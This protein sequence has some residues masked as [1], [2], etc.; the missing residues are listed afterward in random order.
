MAYTGIG[1]VVRWGWVRN[2]QL[3]D[4]GVDKPMMGFR[5]PSGVVFLPED[6]RLDV[7]LEFA[8]TVYVVPESAFDLAAALGARLYFGGPD[9]H[10]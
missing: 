1:T 7:F 5:V 3:S 8:P 9:T 10:L 4:W 6:R 2:V